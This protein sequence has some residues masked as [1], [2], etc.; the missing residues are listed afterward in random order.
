MA[1]RIIQFDNTISLDSFTKSFFLKL[2]SF[3]GK[4][5]SDNVVVILIRNNLAQ[6]NPINRHLL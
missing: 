4:G 2:A 5:S 6:S 1:S 3:N